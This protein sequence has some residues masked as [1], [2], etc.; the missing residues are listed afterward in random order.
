MPKD[1]KSDQIVIRPAT[2]SDATRIAEINYKTWLATYVNEEL[3]LT[4][5]YLRDRKPPN[6][7]RIAKTQEKLQNAKLPCWVA[8]V[9][10]EVIGY[11]MPW[12]DDQG[13]NRLGGLYILPGFH[14]RGIGSTLIKKTI[15]NY[16][17]EEKVYL[18][19]ATY[20][21]K[22]I[23]FYQK[24]GFVINEEKGAYQHSLD[25]NHSMPVYEMY[26]PEG[27]NRK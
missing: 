22:A 3:G 16:P 24:H 10:G 6:Q 12:V 13:R 17:A 18:E 25:D 20:N 11:S 7:S 19:T 27:V 9:D 1:V 4:A 5:E 2:I 14:G 15:A 21:E 26:L 8:E 23:R